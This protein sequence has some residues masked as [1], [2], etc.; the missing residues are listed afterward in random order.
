MSY[1]HAGDDPSDLRQRG[2]D[3]IDRMRFDEQ[4]EQMEIRP[5]HPFSVP[6]LFGQSYRTLEMMMRRS[7][8]TARLVRKADHACR[9]RVE[10]WIGRRQGLRCELERPF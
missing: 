9:S 10:D 8:I 6:A 3:D 2:H 7:E 5:R 1:T 4:P